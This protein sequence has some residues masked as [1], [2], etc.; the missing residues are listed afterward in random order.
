MTTRLRALSPRHWNG[1]N[2]FM[3]ARLP[4]DTPAAIGTPTTTD[5]FQPKL[6]YL[7]RRNPA[8]SR[9]EFVVRWRRHGALGMSLPRWR[10]VARYVH[11]D[12]LDP[13]APTATI[14]ADHDAIG[15]V[16]HRSPAARAAHLADTGSRRQMEQD[17][18]E[19][20]ARPIVET[21]LLAR[22]HL[23]LAPPATSATTV[24]LTR[25]LRA[26]DGVPPPGE[27]FTREF[28]ATRQRALAAAGAPVR[29]HVLDVPLPPERGAGW[30]LCCAA[31]EEFWFDDL[32]AAQAA[33]GALATDPV[34]PASLALLTNE[35]LLY[36]T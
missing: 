18:L 16:W 13:S 11:C 28:V 24:K 5:A 1:E 21:C 22:E 6:I 17:E 26:G 20:F 33:A 9:R 7:A 30:G 2:S 4:S 3:T 35:V 36:T 25:L 23:L 27:A 14:D 29:G 15:I 32:T 12:A 34:A 10:N 19:T 31:I 8:L